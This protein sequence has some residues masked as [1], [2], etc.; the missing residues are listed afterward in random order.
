MLTQ[1][2]LS[3]KIFTGKNVALIALDVFHF[4]GIHAAAGSFISMCLCCYFNFSHGISFQW[5]SRRSSDVSRAVFRQF[6]GG[7]Q[8]I[9]QLLGRPL[10]TPG[11]SIIRFLG[12]GKSCIN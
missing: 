9:S 8:A 11:P 10:H 3:L 1:E 6:S 4:F 2:N 7:H 12:L 5:L